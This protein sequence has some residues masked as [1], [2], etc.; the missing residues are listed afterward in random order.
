M[1]LKQ[2]R[3]SFIRSWI[4]PK[5]Y[6]LFTPTYKYNPLS[7]VPGLLEI[8]TWLTPLNP[9]TTTQEQHPTHNNP[10]I[11][12]NPKT[13]DK[14]SDY[15]NFDTRR[16]LYQQP[17]VGQEQAHMETITN[18]AYQDAVLVALAGAP[19]TTSRSTQEQSQLQIE[20]QTLEDRR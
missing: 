11:P 2:R 20:G 4:T 8:Y 12:F 17:Q 1:G 7:L 9:H 3:H 10:T 14:H 5:Q 6:T 18:P 13:G 16:N 19:S 15:L